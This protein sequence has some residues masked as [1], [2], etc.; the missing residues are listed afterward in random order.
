M[1]R[2]L[3]ATLAAALFA[4]SGPEDSFAQANVFLGGGATFPV[5]DFGELANTGWQG[6]GGVLVPVG[7]AGISV[8]AEGFYGSNNHEIDGNKTK[9][10][11]GLGLVGMQWGD[12]EGLQPAVFGGLGLMKRS[13]TSDAIPILDSSATSLAW[14][15][16]AGVGYPI[17]GV[18]GFLGASYTSGT[19]DENFAIRYF[20]IGLS[21][22]IP[23]G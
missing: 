8:G 18:S 15:G 12:P 10:Y 23:V 20:T 21:A 5:S 9:L 7:D 4:L 3:S 1:R 2:L 16:G 6:W 14:G 13:F 19:G 17:G 11:G 22:M